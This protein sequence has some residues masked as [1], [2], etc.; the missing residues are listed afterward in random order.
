MDIIIKG[1]QMDVNSRLQQ[2]IERKVQKLS[3]LVDDGARLEVIVSEEK[4]RSARDRF[5]V[6][7]ALTGKTRAV[8]SEM[9]AVNTNAALDLALAKIMTQ[10]GRQKDRQTT[11]KR[12]LAAPVKV[13]SLSRAGF[14]TP[15]TE[16]T[17]E[18][19]AEDIADDQPADNPDGSSIN[20]ER[21]EEIWT[22]IVEI[23]RLPARPLNDQEVITQ[24]EM[25]GLSFFPFFNEATGSVNVMYRL[26]TGGYG[27]LV[28][29]AE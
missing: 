27:L 8:R 12:R 13:L 20:R 1:K 22:K 29:E 18:D 2:F 17:E 16:E 3:R 23:R 5:S 19:F 4:T 21:N 6:Q 26:D 14:L 7:L 10:L 28:P 24:M 9:S 11:A 25:L 15:V